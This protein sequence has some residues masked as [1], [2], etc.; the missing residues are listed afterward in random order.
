M[1]ISEI[2]SRKL[3]F[4]AIR[5]IVNHTGEILKNGNLKLLINKNMDTTK[6]KRLHL[7]N[8]R[9]CGN[10]IITEDKDK[11]VTPMFLP[12]EMFNGCKSGR[13]HSMMYNVPPILVAGYEWYNNGGECLYIRKK[14]ELSDDEININ[15]LPIRQKKVIGSTSLHEKFRK[16]KKP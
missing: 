7:Y 15:A 3:N 14:T 5:L 8:C 9:T 11:G 12:C 4:S 13:M 16:G 1:S 6:E 10:T 2:T